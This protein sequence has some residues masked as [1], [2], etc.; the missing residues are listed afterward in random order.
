MRIHPNRTQPSITLF[1]SVE[2]ELEPGTILARS[3][4]GLLVRYKADNPFG[5]Q[6]IL[7]STPES[8]MALVGFGGVYF[9]EDLRLEETPLGTLGR[10]E[11]RGIHV[12]TKDGKEPVWPQEAAKEPEKTAQ[13]P[14]KTPTGP[15]P[16]KQK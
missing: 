1:R 4:E 8:G 5:P 13:S 7:L 9:A 3:P 14:E 15:K 16:G 11:A 12:M 6:A 10:L 2:G